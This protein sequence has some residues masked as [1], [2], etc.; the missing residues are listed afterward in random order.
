MEFIIFAILI[1]ASLGFGFALKK[2]AP[3]LH[4]IMCVLIVFLTL[5]MLYIVIAVAHGNL[6]LR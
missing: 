2:A 5:L 4:I 1:G 6:A 3:K